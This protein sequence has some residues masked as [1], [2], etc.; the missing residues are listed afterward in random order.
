MT[1]EVVL[2]QSDLQGRL[3][4]DY[5]TTDELG[6]LDS[7]LV[8]VHQAQVVGLLAKGS[9]WQRPVYG[10]NHIANIGVDSIVLHQRDGEPP[11]AAA[12]PMTGLEVWTDTGSYIGQ[13]VDYQFERQGAILQYLFAQVGQVGLYGLTPDAIISTGRKRMMVSAQAIEQAEYFP[14]EVPPIDQQDWQV[15]AQSKAQTIATQVQQRAQNW[16]D[17]AQERWLN[18]D[19]N[20]QLQEQA[21]GLR[22]RLSK[23][24]KRLRPLNKALEN[25]LENTLDRLSEPKEA[26]AI[27]LDSFEVWEDD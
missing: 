13:I 17:Y 9:M 25:T 24:Q 2:R 16:S 7:L 12:Q 5:E 22:S 15:T 23:A 14:D 27:D 4:L 20:E 8:D 11:S 10:W 3:I 26:P 6:W 1:D 21:Q 19:F 18:E